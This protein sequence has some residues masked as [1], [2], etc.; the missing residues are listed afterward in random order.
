VI[1]LTPA[2]W[3]AVALS[4]RVAALS[5]ALCA[6]P[7]I[8]CG[9]LLARR[10]FAGKAILDAV[11]HLPLVLPPVA[12]G[13]LLL[14][15]LG[16]KTPVGSWLRETIGIEL[17]FDWKGA[18]LAAAVVG[19]PLMVRAVRLAIELVD[20]RLEEA[21]RTLGA[22]PLRTFFS[23]TLPLSRPGVITGL[24]LVFVRSLGEFGA[25]IMF[26][27]N[28]AGKTTTLPLAMFTWT[29]I[30]GGDTRVVRLMCVSIGLS[31]GALLLAEW[32]GRRRGAR[33]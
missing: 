25:T 26:V 24:I 18:A 23:V 13:Y 15:T 2:E 3:D 5:T 1:A 20:V 19:F 27:G 31:L 22:G 11:I 29:H 14:I 4:L 21:A 32:L 16:R 33:P 9:W 10:R 8:A 17:S 12:V 30:P 6:I 7:A 28:I